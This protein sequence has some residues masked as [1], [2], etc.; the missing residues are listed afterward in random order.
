MHAAQVHEVFLAP[1]DVHGQTAV[2]LH[3]GMVAA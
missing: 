3:D 2:A 1:E